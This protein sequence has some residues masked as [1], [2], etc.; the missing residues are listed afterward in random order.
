MSRFEDGDQPCNDYTPQSG[1]MPGVANRHSCYG[2]GA[3]ACAFSVSFCEKCAKDHHEGGWDNCPA[4]LRSRAEAAEAELASLR[5]SGARIKEFDAAWK[6]GG[7]QKLSTII[8]GDAATHIAHVL[9]AGMLKMEAKNF[10]TWTLN[11]VTDEPAQYSLVLQRS[12]GKTVEQVLGELRSDIA[13][14]RALLEE[15]QPLLWGTRAELGERISA[16]LRR[17]APKEASDEAR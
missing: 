16:Y 13:E 5:E 4:A 12:P 14:A 11:T 8:Q 1:S 7:A 2:G 17:T 10:V 9:A 3:G 15:V 6:E